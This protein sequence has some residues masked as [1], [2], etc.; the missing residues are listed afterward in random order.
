M[1]EFRKNQ[2]SDKPYFTKDVHN[3]LPLL[4]TFR[5]LG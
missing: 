1:D 5:G 4:S 2:P 3:F